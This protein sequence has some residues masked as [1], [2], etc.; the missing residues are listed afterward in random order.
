ML[1]I[2][3]TAVAGFFKEISDSLGKREVSDH[4]QS[5][6]T[7]GFLSIFWVAI[8]FIVIALFRHSF[9]FSLASLPTFGLRAVLEIFQT[10]AGIRGMVDAERGSY[11]LIRTGTIPLLLIADIVLGYSISSYQIAG[12]F[13]IFIS[14]LIFFLNHGVSKQGLG[15]TIFSTVNAAVTISLF[16]Y[17]ITHFNSIEAEQILIFLIIMVYLLVSARF[18]GYENPI[19]A[20]KK[21]VFFLQASSSG[22]GDLLGS[23]A[24]IFA[25][26]S[27]ITTSQRSFAVLWALFSGNLYFHEKEL[28]RKIFSLVL[29]ILGLILLI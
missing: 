22:L 6:Y 8:F 9:I 23:F 7:M 1:G 18:W 14:L 15:W 13:I 21:P 29:I 3:F 19:L 2:L 17:N 24:F 16:K 4:K 5:I 12:I 10:Y 27:I 20:L 26:A 11:S 28:G 25:S